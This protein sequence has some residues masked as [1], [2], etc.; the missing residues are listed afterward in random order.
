MEY[1][2]AFLIIS[3]MSALCFTTTIVAVI[4]TYQLHKARKRNDQ[5]LNVIR[6]LKTN[7]NDLTTVR[8]T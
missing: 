6:S 3:V 8:K 5:L 1:S 2:T 4:A 7:L